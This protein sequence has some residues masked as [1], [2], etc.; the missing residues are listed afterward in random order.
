MSFLHEEEKLEWDLKPSVKTGIAEKV[1]GSQK[2]I[3]NS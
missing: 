2:V 1:T 3:Q